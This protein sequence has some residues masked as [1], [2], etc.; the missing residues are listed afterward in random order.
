LRLPIPVAIETALSGAVFLLPA[1]LL[2]PPP[3]AD[4][5]KVMT[6]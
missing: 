1:S 2:R 4:F 5:R 3:Q 6:P